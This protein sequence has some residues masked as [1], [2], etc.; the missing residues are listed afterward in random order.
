MFYDL[1]FCIEI[2]V[3]LAN[4]CG[5]VDLSVDNFSLTVLGGGLGFHFHSELHSKSDT[6]EVMRNSGDRD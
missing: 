3:I 1:N 5:C 2:F 6:T 4:Y